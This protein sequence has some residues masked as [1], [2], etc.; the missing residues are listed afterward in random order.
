M[1]DL[2][3]PEF[4]EYGVC[5][6]DRHLLDGAVAAYGFRGAWHER[7]GSYT[8]SLNCIDFAAISLAAKNSLVRFLNDVLLSVVKFK[9]K[10]ASENGELDKF[11]GVVKLVDWS[12]YK[13]YVR[14]QTGYVNIF[15]AEYDEPLSFAKCQDD[16]Y[17]GFVKK[18]IRSRV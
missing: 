18:W 7:E 10:K 1:S 4:L 8:V 3:L 2:K 17:L 15:M 5:D 6:V 9:V 14:R 12:K 11:S 13:V 16:L